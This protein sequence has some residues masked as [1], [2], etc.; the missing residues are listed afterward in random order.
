MSPSYY[1]INVSKDGK[2]FFATA[3]RS[4]TSKHRMKEAFEK[5]KEA[6]TEEE[7]YK[8]SVTYWESLG[9]GVDVK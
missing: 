3:P 9:H 2:H 5:F 8:I 6:F 4:L 1:E 7:G